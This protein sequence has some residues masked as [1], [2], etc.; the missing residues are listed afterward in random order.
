MRCFCATE[1]A[2]A[3]TGCVTGCVGTGLCGRATVNIKRAASLRRLLFD[4]TTSIVS[5]GT[6]FQTFEFESMQF[7]VTVTVQNSKLLNLKV[8]NLEGIFDIFYRENR[9]M[10]YLPYAICIMQVVPHMSQ[11]RRFFGGF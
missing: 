3:I 6:K 5:N 7:G 4:R 8:C 9:K 10:D 11:N 1:R 2:G